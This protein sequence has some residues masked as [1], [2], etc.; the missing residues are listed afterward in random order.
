M[1][2]AE[3]AGPC[4]WGGGKSGQSAA[5]DVRINVGNSTRADRTKLL[6]HIAVRCCGLR[7]KKAKLIDDG[8]QQ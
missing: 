5:N 3:S 1:R 4:P 2:G 7:V 8:P 6:D